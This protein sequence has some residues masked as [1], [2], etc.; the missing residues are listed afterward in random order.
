MKTARLPLD[1]LNYRCSVLNVD[2]V[3]HV[4]QHFYN[5]QELGWKNAIDECLPKREKLNIL[6]VDTIYNSFNYVLEQKES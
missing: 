3:V 5:H 6:K 1:H 2:T 4:L